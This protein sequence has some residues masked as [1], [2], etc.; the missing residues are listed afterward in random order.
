MTPPFGPRGQPVTNIHTLESPILLD[1][2]SPEHRA[3][4]QIMMYSRERH[5]FTSLLIILGCEAK[6][7]C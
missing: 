2:L 4:F 1:V 3:V 5:L 7:I 6:Q